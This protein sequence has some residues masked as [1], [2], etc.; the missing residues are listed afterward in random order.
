[1]NQRISTSLAIGLCALLL[2]AEVGFAQ[3]KNPTVYPYGGI[4]DK[5]RNQSW[6]LKTPLNLTK[7]SISAEATFDSIALFQGGYVR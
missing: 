5:S 7:G 1:M 3:E 4:P 2:F 6:M